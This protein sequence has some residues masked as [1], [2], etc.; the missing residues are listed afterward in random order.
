VFN[1]KSL[2]AEEAEQRFM[3]ENRP[4]SLLERLIR[5]EEIANAAIFLCS[6]LASAFNGSAVRVDEGLVRSVF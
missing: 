5:P 2:S 4:T 6:P 1:D 3:R